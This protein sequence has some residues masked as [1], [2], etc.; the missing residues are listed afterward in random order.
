M[1]I[2]LFYLVFILFYLYIS[3]SQ[4]SFIKKEAGS[5]ILLNAKEYIK[6]A[7]YA[8]AKENLNIKRTIFDVIVFFWWMKK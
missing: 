8:I 1:I 4:I 2:E 6:S 7:E 3:V 5:P